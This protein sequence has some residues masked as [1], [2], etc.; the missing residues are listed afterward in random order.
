MS[1]TRRLPASPLSKQSHRCFNPY[2]KSLDRSSTPLTSLRRSRP[3]FTR[4]LSFKETKARALW[5]VT[6]AQVRLRTPLSVC[7]ARTSITIRSLCNSQS[8]LGRVPLTYENSYLIQAT[9][10]RQ[11]TK[12]RSPESLTRNRSPFS[13]TCPTNNIINFHSITL[14]S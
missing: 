9:I 4:C 3:N 8:R 13:H 2:R 10:F 11:L 6:K 5:A 7:Y 14:I 12:K 1:Q